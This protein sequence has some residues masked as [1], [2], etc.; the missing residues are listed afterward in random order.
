M[1][2]TVEAR[3]SLGLN[4]EDAEE[5][6]KSPAQLHT[7]CCTPSVHYKRTCAVRSNPGHFA[8]HSHLEVIETETTQWGHVY[9]EVVR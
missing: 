9:Q 4:S 3:W 2:E 1:T 7:T 8:T 6:G 5:L